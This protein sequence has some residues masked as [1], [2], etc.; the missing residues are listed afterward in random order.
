MDVNNKGRIPVHNGF[1]GQMTSLLWW[2]GGVG[3]RRGGVV[4]GE[5]MVGGGAEVRKG[6]R[7]ILTELVTSNYH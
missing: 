4:S 7:N 2:D 3:V 5:E 1:A 6:G